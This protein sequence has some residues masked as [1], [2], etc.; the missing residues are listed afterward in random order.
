ME[1][2]L[3][4]FNHSD[5]CT[6]SYFQPVVAFEDR[7]EAEY[8]YLMLC[9]AWEEARNQRAAVTVDYRGVS[10]VVIGW[11]FSTPCWESIPMIPKQ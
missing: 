11:N 7:D 4:G 8:L 6:Y 10:L 1:T 2:H 9:E 5:D 3:V